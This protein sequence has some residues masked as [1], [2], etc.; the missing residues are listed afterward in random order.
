MAV[1]DLPPAATRVTVLRHG[2][3][4][5]RAHVMR[6][7]LDDPLSAAGWARMASVLAH[8]QGGPVDAVATS[9]LRRCQEFARAWAAERGLGL[10]VV[11][12]FREMSFGAWE[13]LSSQEAANQAP[14]HY[15]RFRAS[16]GKVPPPGGEGLEALHLRVSAAWAAWLADA[17]GGH[18]LL[19]THAGVMRALLMEVAGLP[20]DHVWR[21]AL[22]E[23]AH[24][25]VS[26][27][28][29]EGPVL[30]NLNPCAA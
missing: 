14:E 23:A 17:A 2:E 15:A 5:G 10:T 11:D 25:Q 28:K 22:P 26:V 27:L 20:A 30:L 6:G 24:F 21:V 16:A 13:G 12:G 19:V 9:P 4:E 7:S 18:R 8:L 29:G 1:P 3:V